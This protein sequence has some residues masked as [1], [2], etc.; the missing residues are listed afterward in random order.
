MLES[1]PRGRTRRPDHKT[2]SRRRFRISEGIAR[3][4]SRGRGLSR[5]DRGAPA[6]TAA[7]SNCQGRVG[8]TTDSLNDFATRSISAASALNIGSERRSELT[9]AEFRGGT[10]ADVLKG[11]HLPL[12]VA[13]ATIGR[14]PIL[15]CFLPTSP[16]VPLVRDGVRRYRNQGVVARSH[17]PPEQA[18]DLQLWLLGPDGSETIQ[19]GVRS[20]WQSNATTRWPGSSCGCHL[21]APGNVTK[22]SQASL[23]EH[24]WRVRGTLIH[25][26]RL[27]SATSAARS[28]IERLGETSWCALALAL[29][30]PPRGM[31]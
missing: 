28:S 11:S 19:S 8:S 21:I 25:R 1:V 7:G 27:R 29:T 26:R 9:S 6:R 10:G 20:P 24:S 15:F 31:A 12:Q 2:D 13:T 14:F 17:L 30:S 23:H 4:L 5:R 18:S 16:D 3:G 22:R